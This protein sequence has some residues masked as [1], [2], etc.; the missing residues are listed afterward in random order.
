[1]LWADWVGAAVNNWTGR[2]ASPPLGASSAPSLSGIVNWFAGAVH[3]RW[4]R[5]QALT[6]TEQ[7][8]IQQLDGGLVESVLS[9]ERRR[10]MML[11]VSIVLVTQI[12]RRTCGRKATKGI[13]CFDCG[14]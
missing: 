14:R 12:I 13:T 1:V 11:R 6:E 2:W 7:D 10:G 4:V 3:P 5:F 8:Q 9:C